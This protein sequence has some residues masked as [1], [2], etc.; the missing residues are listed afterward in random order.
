MKNQNRSNKG[1]S[2]VELIVVIAIMAILVGIL[3]P[4]LMKQIDKSRLSKDKQTVDSVYQAV[5]TAMAD[6]TAYEAFDASKYGTVADIL[7][8]S[9]DF[10]K[11]VVDNLKGKTNVKL[12]SKDFKGLEAKDMAVSFDTNE[13]LTITVTNKNGGKDIV[14]PE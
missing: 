3:A 2:L 13:N 12:T 14:I 10:G 4:S 1:F 6:P 11:E 8:D 5:Q 9:G 7:A